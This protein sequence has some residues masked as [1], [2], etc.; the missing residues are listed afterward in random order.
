MKFQT[1]LDLGFSLYFYTLIN[2]SRR[3]GLAPQVAELSATPCSVT[4]QLM[5]P[6]I[7]PRNWRAAREVVSDNGTKPRLRVIWSR[8]RSTWKVFWARAAQT[9]ARPKQPSKKKKKKKVNIK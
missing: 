6:L 4:P 9:A 8:S 2:H 5:A 1:R 3:G 7:G